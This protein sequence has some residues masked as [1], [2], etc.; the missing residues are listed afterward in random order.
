MVKAKVTRTCIDH[1]FIRSSTEELYSAALGTAL[2]DHRMVVATMTGIRHIQHAPKFITCTNS[3]VLQ[4]K[5][6]EVDW[7]ITKS[8]NCSFQIYDYIKGAFNRAYGSSKTKKYTQTSR[9]NTEGWVN[10]KIR[11]KCAETDECFVKCLKDPTNTILRLEYN[12][13]RNKSHK[14]V[15]NSRNKYIADKLLLNKNDPRKS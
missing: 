14:L 7:E 11:K 5:L 12:R 15:Q 9:R 10:N 13:L 4:E 3:K 1:I 8:M 2:A 6:N